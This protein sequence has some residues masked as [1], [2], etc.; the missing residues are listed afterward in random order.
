MKSASGIQFILISS[1]ISTIS[2]IIMKRA[3][4]NCAEWKSA[5]YSFFLGAVLPIVIF[6]GHIMYHGIALKLN[7]GSVI[8]GVMWGCSILLFNYYISNHGFTY[9]VFINRAF[10]SIFSIMLGIMILGEIPSPKQIVA[11]VVI[12]AG[13]L[14]L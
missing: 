11:L 14:L 1:F 13:I 5:S 7:T 2:A 10:L 9:T 12:V 4:N 6:W 3:M 8:S